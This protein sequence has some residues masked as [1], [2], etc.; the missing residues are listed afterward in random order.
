MNTRAL[1]VALLLSFSLSTPGIG[2]SQ[3]KDQLG[4]VNFAN[5]CSPAVQ[6]TFQR[7]VAML[8]SFRYGEAEKTFREVLAQDPSCAIATWGIAAILMSN[9]LTGFGPS[10]E[11][12]ER[13]QAAIDQGRKVGA[14]TQRERDYI[15]S[16]AVYYDDWANRPERVRQQNR[17]RAFEALAARYPDDDEAQIFSALYIAG[18][19]SQADQTYAA[20][21]KAAAILE[22]EFAKYPDHPGVAH[23]LIHVYDA[24]PLAAQGL[25]AARL[26]AG[27]AADA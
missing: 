6:E 11:W 17:A 23:Y 5:S 24:P 20:Y 8:H 19:Q 27:I 1:L 4:T 22:K 3:S 18:T 9:P 21:R 13:A 7:G 26:Y 2:L 25:T 15:E 16:V 12:A 14:K 10:K